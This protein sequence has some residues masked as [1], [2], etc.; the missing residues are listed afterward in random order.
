MPSENIQWFPGH[1]AKTRRIMRE[2]LPDVDLV[3]EVC[4]ARIPRSSRN[5]ELRSIIGEKP[6]LTLCSKAD[7]ADPEASSRW[8]AVMRKEGEGCLFI[9]GLRGSM[10]EI[11]ASVDALLTE[12]RQSYDRRGMTGRALRAMVVGIPNAGKSSLINRLA[13]AKKAKVEDRP[14]VT[15]QKQWV[16]T[17]IGLEL[18]DMPGVLWPKFEEK[19][20]GENLAITGAIRDEILDTE[21]VAVILVGRLR[22]TYPELLAARYRLGT[23]SEWEE[24]DDYSL[25]LLI[26][27]K[28]GFIVSGGEVSD[29]RTAVMLLDEFRAGIIGRI[30][31]E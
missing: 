17:S 23:M 24:L 31:L 6:L 26:G 13:G 9:D 19:R 4:D 20:V 12:K 25:F 1:M 18:L 28:R 30:T 11:R 29:E 16:T 27:K 5:P 15:R 3:I 10:G 2:C 21:T 22:K 14:G 7:L 8:K